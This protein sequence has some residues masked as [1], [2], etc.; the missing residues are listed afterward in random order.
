MWRGLGWEL[1][2]GV[3]MIAFLFSFIG[4]SSNTHTHVQTHTHTHT[5]SKQVFSRLFKYFSLFFSSDPIE[6]K[7][8]VNPFFRMAVKKR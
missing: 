2:P 5:H 4:D 8:K 3:E 7:T 6:K 1:G